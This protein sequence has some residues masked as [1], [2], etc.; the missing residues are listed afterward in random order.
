VKTSSSLSRRPDWGRH[1][2]RSDRMHV[3]MTLSREDALCTE[4]RKG[5]H[6]YHNAQE[7]VIVPEYKLIYVKIRKVASTSILSGLRKAFNNSQDMCGTRAVNKSC[8][9]FGG[10]GRRCSRCSSKC[11]TQ[12][13][14]ENYFVFSI[15]RD[16]VR[17]FYS[18][19]S[20]GIYMDKQKASFAGSSQAGRKEWMMQT[21]RSMMDGC[22]PAYNLHMESQTMSLATPLSNGNML[23]IDFI[24]QLE[25]LGKDFERMAN[26]AKEIT[27][28]E[29]P[30]DKL[31]R[32][33]THLELGKSS[34]QHSETQEI[35]DFVA[36]A[37][38][39]ELDALVRAAYVQDYAC[40]NTGWV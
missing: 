8:A 18:G 37:R 20:Q 31:S 35:E 21:L 7:V 38:D 1:D 25:H 15:V 22:S 6:P 30:S 29:I 2:G 17:R 13:E 40:F 19:F 26:L 27:G 33:L 11:L 28:V 14:V 23:P 9:A 5:I 36:V 39:D 32:L 16:P 4:G 3:P 10:D 12:T 24:G 34:N